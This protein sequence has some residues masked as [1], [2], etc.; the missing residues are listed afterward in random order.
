MT[1][2]YPKQVNQ[3][4]NDY[5]MFSAHEYRTNRAYDGQSGANKG[6]ALG[7]KKQGSQTIV[8]YMPNST[9]GVSQ[10]NSW[11]EMRNDGPLGMMKANMVSDVG[12]F[13]SNASGNMKQMQQEGKALIDKQL[14]NIKSNA[15]G[16]AKQGVLHLLGQF[17]GM[18]PNQIMAVNKGQIYNPNI[19]LLYESPKLRQFGFNFH[20]IP[21]N[22]SETAEINNIIMEFKK[23][24]APKENG[25]MFEVPCVWQVTYMSGAG[26]N[27]NMN[28]FKRAALV[29]IVVQANPSS[30]MHVSF[31]DG[32]PITTSIQLMFQE[33]DIITRDD[34]TSVGTNQGY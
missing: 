20:L 8:L 5:I 29:D 27:L 19:E 11:G 33:T 10:S 32:M 30:D 9:P 4:D 15:G 25:A 18:T 21:K 23:W 1:L 22:A 6:G 31:A 16:A 7:P 2:S 14:K 28:A 26:K 12:N 34:H 3:G 24:S 17:A 13:V